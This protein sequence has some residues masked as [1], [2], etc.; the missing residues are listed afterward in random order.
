MRSELTQFELFDETN[1]RYEADWGY[2]ETVKYEKIMIVKFIGEYKHGS[3][4]KPDCSYIKTIS[5]AIVSES[6]CRGF[7][8]DLSELLYE[9]GDDIDIIFSGLSDRY[10]ST[11]KKDD[12][13]EPLYR[14]HT[15]AEAILIGPLC[16]P[17]LTSLF[18]CDPTKQFEYI[19]EDLNEA[20]NY[21]DQKILE[22]KDIEY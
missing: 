8:F 14:L 2:S 3:Q 21:V 12:D 4:G 9:W 16:K 13:D 5:R 7:I 18:Q 10:L 15:V 11:D 1:L 22:G 20:W 6:D 17:A 19:F